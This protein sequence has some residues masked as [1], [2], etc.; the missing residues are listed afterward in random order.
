MSKRVVVVKKPP[1]QIVETSEYVVE[2]DGK[3]KGGFKDI[4]DAVEYATNLVLAC[5]CKK[6]VVKATITIEGEE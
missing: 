1:M 4:I 3:G 2:A 5:E 6:A